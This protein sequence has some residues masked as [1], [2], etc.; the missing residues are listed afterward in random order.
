MCLDG[1]EQWGVGSTGSMIEVVMN[2]MR[3][4][5]CCVVSFLD[6]LDIF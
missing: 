1:A 4:V 6:Q 3:F 2:A 5:G